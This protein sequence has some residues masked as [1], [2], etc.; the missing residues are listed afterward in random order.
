MKPDVVGRLRVYLFPSGRGSML[1]F[2]VK[3]KNA[4]EG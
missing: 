1:L 2:Y 4:A 3:I